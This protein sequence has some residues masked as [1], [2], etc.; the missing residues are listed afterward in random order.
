VH[1]IE[2]AQRLSASSSEFFAFF[3]DPG[4]LALLT[5]PWPR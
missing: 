4:N 1:R 2:R 5:P 3:S